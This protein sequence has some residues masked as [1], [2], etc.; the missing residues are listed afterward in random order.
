[1]P[2]R[3]REPRA[4]CVLT[5]REDGKVR[6]GHAQDKQGVAALGGGAG[7][8]GPLF[9][10]NRPED[11]VQ[12]PLPGNDLGSVTSLGVQDPLAVGPLARAAGACS[13]TRWLQVQPPS[14]PCGAGATGLRPWPFRRNQLSAAP[15]REALS[16]APYSPAQVLA[17]RPEDCWVMR[18]FRGCAPHVA[19]EGHRDSPNLGFRPSTRGGPRV[20][21]SHGRR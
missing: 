8:W 9:G 6:P 2:L 12:G 17:P 5:V 21:K 13:V 15:S 11:V 10:M 16:D 18:R 1:M 20:F 19:L 4:L 14:P 7:G 3:P